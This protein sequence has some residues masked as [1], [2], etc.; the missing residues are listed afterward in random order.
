MRNLRM[1]FALLIVPVLL[2]G[3][4]KDNDNDDDLLLAGALLLWSQNQSNAQAT[5]TASSVRAT[6]G[7]VATSLTTAAKNSQIA[8]TLPG[9]L[10]DP[11]MIMALVHKKALKKML[12]SQ[13]APMSIP[14]ALTSS[15]GTCNS[16]SCDAT[17]NGTTNCTNGGT[18]T[19]DNVAFK[20]SIPA[21]GVAGS[22]Y[23]VTM[24]GN[25]NLASCQNA[26]FDYMAFPNYVISS[27]SG[28][29]TIDGTSNYTVSSIVANGASGF[30]FDYSLKDGYTVNSTGLSIGGAAAVTIS[31]LVN[32]LDLTINSVTSNYSY[33]SSATE[34]TF[35][36]TYNDTV[37]GTVAVSGTVG[38]GNVNVSKTF[39][40]DKFT[41]D[42]DCTIKLSGDP[43]SVGSCDITPK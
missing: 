4:C 40:A 15:N 16:T 7:G 22:S 35:K 31:N 17:L 29:L 21:G 27:A 18:L 42:V 13:F 38:G 11:K 10:K 25:L 37:T 14:T 9:N 24:A 3:A 8:F 12:G 23:A 33:T 30:I 28:P 41:Y 20:F 26:G 2:A 1:I 36:G 39:S 6:V 5:Q 43:I 34:V 19:M 32:N